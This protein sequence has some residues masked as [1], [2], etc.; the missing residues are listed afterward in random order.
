MDDERDREMKDEFGALCP[1]WVDVFG[2]I[3]DC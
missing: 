2:F 1:S 3:N